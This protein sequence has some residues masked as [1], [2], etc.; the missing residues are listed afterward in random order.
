MLRG[1]S[2]KASRVHCYDYDLSGSV[3]AHGFSRG[4]GA[5]SPSFSPGRPARDNATV[6]RHFSGGNGTSAE[7]ESCKDD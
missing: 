2:P 6:A 4:S 1:F 7:L 3:Q 5:L